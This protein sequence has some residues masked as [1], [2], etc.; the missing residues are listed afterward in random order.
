M[1]GFASTQ[2]LIGRR[3]Q[4]QRRFRSLDQIHERDDARSA[5]HPRPKAAPTT[6]STPMSSLGLPVGNRKRPITC[7]PLTHLL[8]WRAASSCSAR[9]KPSPISSASRFCRYATFAFPSR[10]ACKGHG[11]ASSLQ[12]HRVVRP[13]LAHSRSSS[14]A[15][16]RPRLICVSRSGSRGLRGDP[17]CRSTYGG[18]SGLRIIG[19]P[20]SPRAHVATSALLAPMSRWRADSPAPCEVLLHACRRRLGVSAAAADHRAG[21]AA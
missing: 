21:E 2:V 4:A 7:V 20:A 6:A 13:R 5:G 3:R 10:A 8:C 9:C 12:M 19:S 1:G 18:T 11:A 14:P 15:S 17:R 16:R